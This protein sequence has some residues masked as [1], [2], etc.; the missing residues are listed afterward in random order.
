M[1]S[2]LIPLALGVAFIAGAVLIN[3]Q[4]RGLQRDDVRDVAGLRTELDSVQAAL[5]SA[6]T[7]ADST[8]LSESISQRT[9]VLGR[10]EFHIPSRQEAIDT[11]WSLTGP[12][13][14]LTF[15]GALFVVLAEVTRRR[16]RV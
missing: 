14:V 8:S 10:R 11:W 16:A 6:T 7:G 2:P 9:Y 13:V 5:K 12:G 3:V 4:Q 1:K 15:V